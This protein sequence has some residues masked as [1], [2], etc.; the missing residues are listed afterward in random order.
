MILP[1]GI[2]LV[3]YLFVDA[4]LEGVADVG[5]ASIHMRQAIGMSK[6]LVLTVCLHIKHIHADSQYGNHI[7]V[8]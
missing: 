6:S 8:L 1:V 2:N 7:T 5:K 4:G 3:T